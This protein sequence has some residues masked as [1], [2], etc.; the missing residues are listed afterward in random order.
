MSLNENKKEIKPRNNNFFYLENSSPTF[1]KIISNYRNKRKDMK[2]KNKS[3]LT[4]VEKAR[5]KAENMET[6][7]DYM[8]KEL[9]NERKFTR[10]LK[11]LYG[12]KAEKH[13]NELKNNEEF[14]IKLNK[15]LFFTPNEIKRFMED[16]INKRKKRGSLPLLSNF[17]INKKKSIFS[18]D[19]LVKSTTTFKNEKKNYNSSKNSTGMSGFYKT[20][21]NMK[22][23]NDN[24]RKNEINKKA[25]TNLK[26]ENEIP[27]YNKR[28]NLIYYNTKTESFRDKILNPSNKSSVNKNKT[29]NE[30]YLNRFAYLDEL[31]QINQEFLKTKDGFRKHFKINDYGCNK[32]K[33][34]YEYLSRK[35]FNKYI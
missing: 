17:I 18:I 30:F 1:Q 29:N 23:L 12:K 32:S 31:S 15:N 4:Y 2:E 5:Y 34:L 25:V 21:P 13:Y 9:R 35:F 8:I 20:S 14:R 7:N 33:I 19:K 22:I 26:T 28:I 11:I 3:I 10:Q 16:K 6:E 24:K 27:T